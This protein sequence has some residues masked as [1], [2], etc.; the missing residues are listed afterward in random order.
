[1][2]FEKVL[3]ELRR[4]DY[5]P[6]HHDLVNHDFSSL[7]RTQESPYLHLQHTVGGFEGAGIVN[8]APERRGMG[9]RGCLHETA[10]DYG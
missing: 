3:G 7:P 5:R 8:V 4:R 6:I 9:L 2:R 1:M 10:H